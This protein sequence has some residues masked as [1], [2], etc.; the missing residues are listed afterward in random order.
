M[1]R[2]AFTI[3]LPGEGNA[4][5]ADYFGLVSGR[6]HDKFELLGLTAVHSDLVDAPY[7][8][9]FPLVLECS[10]VEVH[11]LGLHTQFIGEIKDVKVEEACLRDDGHID[12]ELLR[13]IL[14]AMDPGSYYAIGSLIGKAYSIGKEIGA[15]TTHERP[16]IDADATPMDLVKRYLEGPAVLGAAV[17]GM[18]DA[19]LRARP[20]PEK[21]TSQEVVN[22]VLNSERS[23]TGRM[24][25]AIA[26]EEPPVL[27]PMGAG[28]NA[29]PPELR[30]VA[31]DLDALQEIRERT[32]AT[33][34]GLAPEVWD[35][36]AMRREDREV[37]LRQV[38]LLVVRHLEGHV[39][40]IEEKRVA[41]G[42]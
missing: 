21:M 40:A 1:E 25:R 20:I 37:T 6:D 12:M 4:A 34:R 28:H 42:L 15:G 27:A 29:M 26:G 18:D 31:A 13:P 7:V 10:V 23:M 14:F 9:E 36:V 22:H 5:Q 30:D 17:A 38:L 33:L 19:Q 3:S 41:L 35:R 2:R 16:A 39:T 8:G 32:G 24:E 11:E